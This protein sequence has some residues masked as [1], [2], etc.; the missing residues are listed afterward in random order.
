[1]CRR[2]PSSR[3]SPTSTASSAWTSPATSAISTARDDRRPPSRHTA[4]IR[5]AVGRAR[6]A[7]RRRGVRDVAWARCPGR[8]LNAE[9]SPRGPCSRHLPPRSRRSGRLAS[10]LRGSPVP[11]PLGD[12]MSLA[13]LTLSGFRALMGFLDGSGAD[14]R[15]EA[16]PSVGL[17]RDEPSSTVITL[18]LRCISAL[19]WMT[20]SSE[21]SVLT[22]RQLIR[23]PPVSTAPSVRI[24]ENPAVLTALSAHTARTLCRWSASRVSRSPPLSP[25]CAACLRAGQHC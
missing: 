17:L 21:P 24:C 8:S 23:R 1:M 5:R 14:W 2:A 18:N 15:K 4:R 12:G 16:W 7:G 13:A 10:R 11:I 22:L 25:S 3:P 6:T 9:T 19:E 20:G